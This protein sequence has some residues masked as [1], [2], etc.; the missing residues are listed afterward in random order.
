MTGV[1]LGCIL[2]VLLVVIVSH[3]GLY[4]TLVPPL[5]RYFC[6]AQL[7]ATAY[8]LSCFSLVVCGAYTQFCWDG[9]NC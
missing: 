2:N 3:V 8:S 5:I 1:M 7:C 4:V 9:D 6:F